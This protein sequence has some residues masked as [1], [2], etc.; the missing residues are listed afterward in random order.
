MNFIAKI[1]KTNL[2][3]DKVKAT[4]NVTIDGSYAVHGIKILETA[5]G[6]A[7]VMPN[8]KIGE[9][10]FDTFH[11]I[12]SEARAKLVDAVLSEF[13]KAVDSAEKAETEET[14]APAKSKSTKT[15]N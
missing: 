6:L 8:K 11:P 12:N 5:K 14:S 13:A 1:R 4:V 15:K 9:K 7:V 2:E 10:Y 3:T